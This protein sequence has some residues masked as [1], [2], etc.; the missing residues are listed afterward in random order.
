MRRV[1]T[2]LIAVLIAL[3]PI[4]S[5][6][7]LSE[8]EVRPGDTLYSIA[9][10]F[11]VSEE[12]LRKANSISDPRSLSIGQR[13][14]IPGAYEVEP[15]DTYWSIA[16]RHGMSVDELLELNDRTAETVLRVGEVLLV[17]VPEDGAQNVADG[18]AAANSD[19]AG[20]D[21]ATFDAATSDAG[22]TGEKGRSEPQSASVRKETEVAATDPS[23]RQTVL[24]PHPGERNPVNGKFPG[25][26]ISARA[27]DSVYS[28][29]NGR[30]IY[31]GPHTAFGRVVFVQTDAGY[32]YVYA[33]NSELAVDVGD[34][35]RV[36][37]R[38]G[39][40]GESASADSAQL[41]FSVW[42]NNR[43]IDPSRA[44]RG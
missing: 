42:K 25:V 6:S 2:A 34:R 26:A 5:I 21:A 4:I 29:S 19:G 30:V 18:G 31:S 41:Y 32:L 20:S 36:G 14:T 24:W 12:A 10:R 43:Y 33:G 28:V 17:D 9:R 3:C 1:V 39:S 38:I 11:A 7:A 13:L 44:P 40:V 27:G 23:S 35:V 37:T 22:D 16:R 8:Y 15:G